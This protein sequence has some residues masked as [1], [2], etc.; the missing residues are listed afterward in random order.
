MMG[1]LKGEVQHCS[2]ARQ[3]QHEEPLQTP[4]RRGPGRHHG[5]ESSG[6]Q[7]QIDRV[8]V[9]PRTQ[10]HHQRASAQRLLPSAHQS[11]MGRPRVAGDYDAVRAGVRARRVRRLARRPRKL[12]QGSVLWAGVRS[13]LQQF[14]SP[15]QIAVSSGGTI[16]NKP[17]CKPLTKP[18]IPPSMPGPKE[19]Y[20]KS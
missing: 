15:Q 14:W 11:H 7:R 16:Q 2:T 3:E 20:A 9:V 12:C 5:H 13:L 6:V 10:Q 18:S 1:G 4:E 17:P 8:D 19:S